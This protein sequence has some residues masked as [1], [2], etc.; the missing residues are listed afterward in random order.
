MA[1]QACTDAV[2]DTQLF[3]LFDKYC[4][5]GAAKGLEGPSSAAP[6]M[7]GARFV[8]LFRDADLT[9]EGTSR[10]V[11]ELDII[12]HKVKHV[13]ERKITFEQFKRAIGLFDVARGPTDASSQG[14]SVMQHLLACQGPK[15]CAVCE[16]RVCNIKR[17]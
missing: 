16:V 7:D 14:M 4:R 2:T 17:G 15:V 12:F 3:A 1:P 6:T 8:K 13:G 9:Q 10:D 5:L 11:I